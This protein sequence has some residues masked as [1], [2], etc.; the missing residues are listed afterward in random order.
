MVIIMI[1]PEEVMR[2]HQTQSI[3]IPME[4][5]SGGNRDC[6]GNT[7][8]TVDLDLN[9]EIQGIVLQS[10]RAKFSAST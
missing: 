1:S 8:A 6:V 10:F 4:I 2:V 3:T 9:S 7:V 5:N